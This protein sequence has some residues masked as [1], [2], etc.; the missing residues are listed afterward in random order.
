M[1]RGKVRQQWQDVLLLMEQLPINPDLLQGP[2]LLENKVVPVQ[3]IGGRVSTGVR[4]IGEVLGDALCCAVAATRGIKIDRAIAPGNVSLE[5][6]INA[7]RRTTTPKRRTVADFVQLLPERHRKLIL[8][9]ARV[10]EE[11]GG[12]TL[13]FQPLSITRG[14]QIESA[15]SCR[16]RMTLSGGTVSGCT[17]RIG[18]YQIALNAGDL[19]YR[20]GGV[21]GVIEVPVGQERGIGDGELPIARHLSTC[22]SVE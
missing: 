6:A 11:G 13:N 21:A 3:K 19:V 5:I 20:V 10:E 12:I 15:V 18:A 22:F 8:D 16:P 7:R 2:V 14:A 4:K 1:K 9:C 17:I